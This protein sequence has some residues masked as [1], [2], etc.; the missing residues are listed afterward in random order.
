MPRKD[1][2][3]LVPRWC[4]TTRDDDE[5]NCEWWH[6]YGR[7]THVTSR[8][9]KPLENIII[10]AFSNNQEQPAKISSIP[11]ITVVCVDKLQFFESAPVDSI[12]NERNSRTPVTMPKRNSLDKHTDTLTARTH[13]HTKHEHTNC[14]LVLASPWYAFNASEPARFSHFVRYNGNRDGS[15]REQVTFHYLNWHWEWN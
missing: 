4:R 13:T 11:I 15:Y 1:T 14:D 3:R 9:T 7:P 6:D 12:T 10:V 8:L 2:P 5:N